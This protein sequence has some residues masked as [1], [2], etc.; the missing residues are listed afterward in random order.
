M[1]QGFSAVISL[2][3]LLSAPALADSAVQWSTKNTTSPA[4]GRETCLI[5]GMIDQVIS[6]TAVRLKAPNMDPQ[7]RVIIGGN[8]SPGSMSFLLING[9]RYQTKQDLF[10]YAT[11]AKILAALKQGGSLAVEWTQFPKTSRQSQATFA[12]FSPLA[13]DC[14]KSIR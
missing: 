4:S 5:Y 11:S 3:T 12:D 6:I 8:N 14:E 7:W 10:D 1:I 9:Q 2:A 13:Q